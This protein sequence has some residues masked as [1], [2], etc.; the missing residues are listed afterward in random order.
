MLKFSLLLF[1]QVSAVDAPVAYLLALLA[2]VLENIAKVEL[3]NV[4]AQERRQE[5]HKRREDFS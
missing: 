3:Q 1:G 2:L 4:P 5:A